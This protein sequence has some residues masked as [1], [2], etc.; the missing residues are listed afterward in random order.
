MYMQ[1]RMC[2]CVHINSCLHSMYTGSQVPA[3]LESL[4][5]KSTIG[6]LYSAFFSKS[7]KFIPP[8][9]FGSRTVMPSSSEFFLVNISCNKFSSNSPLEVPSVSFLDIN[10]RN[11][12]LLFAKS[13]DGNLWMT[14]K[15][16]YP[17]FMEAVRKHRH[18][19]LGLDTKDLLLMAQQAVWALACLQPDPRASVSTGQLKRVRQHLH[20]HW[21]MS[22]EVFRA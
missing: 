15:H 11:R 7:P 19:T 22:E 9:L 2:L 13:A 21:A 3:T 20:L 6:Q 5:R 4:A 16:A 18:K 14:S 12:R 10:C 17:P 8:L 1:T